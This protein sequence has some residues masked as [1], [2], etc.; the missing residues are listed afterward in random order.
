MVETLWFFFSMRLLAP[1]TT[2]VV[3]TEKRSQVHFP[4][5]HICAIT[6]DVQT[7]SRQAKIPN[8]LNAST[9]VI[10]IVLQMGTMFFFIFFYV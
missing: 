10:A 7:Q 4:F 3:V 2:T 5:M 6:P 1:A 8:L 9:T